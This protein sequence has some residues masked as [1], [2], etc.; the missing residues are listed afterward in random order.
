MNAEVK[1]FKFTDVRGKEQL[2]L[3]IE[4]EHGK[5]IINIGE[6]TFNEVEKITA[7]NKAKLII[8]EPKTKAK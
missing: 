3:S 6:K 7:V 2:Y 4:A 5:L 8:D 1:A